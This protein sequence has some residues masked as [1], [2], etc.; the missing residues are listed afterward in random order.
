MDTTTLVVDLVG[1]SLRGSSAKRDWNTV[2]VLGSMTI[3]RER[4]EG[5]NYSNS[6][7]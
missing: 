7:A 2:F 5:K 4:I 6:L 3:S 1:I